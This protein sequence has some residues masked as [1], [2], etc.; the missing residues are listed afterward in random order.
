VKAGVRAISS[1]EV[2]GQAK[3]ETISATPV[4]A[5]ESTID[6]RKELVFKNMRYERY[7]ICTVVI[8]ARMEIIRFYLCVLCG[9]KQM[10]AK[11]LKISAKWCSFGLAGLVKLSRMTFW[12]FCVLPD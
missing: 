7:R 12:H 9:K 5:W 2:A 3:P 10:V 4:K 6:T 11:W 1:N 8:P